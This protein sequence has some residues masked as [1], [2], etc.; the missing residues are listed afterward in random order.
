VLEKDVLGR[1]FGP[2]EQEAT[3]EQKKPL[4]LVYSSLCVALSENT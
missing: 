3:G 2:K 4:I 1:I